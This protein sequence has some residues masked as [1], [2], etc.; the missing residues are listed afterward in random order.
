MGASI[1]VQSHSDCPGAPT[2]ADKGRKKEEEK[3]DPSDQTSFAGCLQDDS[4]ERSIRSLAAL[5]MTA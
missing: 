3:A 5:R 4:K 2:N 1:A